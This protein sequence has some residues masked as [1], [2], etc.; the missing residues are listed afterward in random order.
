MFWGGSPSF[1]DGGEQLGGISVV[2][3]YRMMVGGAPDIDVVKVGDGLVVLFLISSDSEQ[4]Q[5]VVHGG[6]GMLA[7]VERLLFGSA[8]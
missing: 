3:P 2:L 5:A 6:I 7:F 1:G 8:G 4:F